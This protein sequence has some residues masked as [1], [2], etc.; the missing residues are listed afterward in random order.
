MFQTG[1]TVLDE[2]RGTPGFLALACVKDVGLDSLVGGDGEPREVVLPRGERFYR[3]L[4][5]RRPIGLAKE[6]IGCKIVDGHRDRE[7]SLERGHI[8]SVTLQDVVGQAR[9]FHVSAGAEQLACRRERLGDFGDHSRRPQNRQLRAERREQVTAVALSPMIGM[10]GDLVDERARRP[11]GADQDADRV[12]AREG[13]HAAAAPDLKVA[14]RPFERGRRHRRLVGEVRR[15]AAIQRID[16]ELD[17]VGATEAVRAHPLRIGSPAA[18]TPRGPAAGYWRRTAR[19][20]R[21]ERQDGR[22]TR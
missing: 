15:P 1:S 16:Q 20:Q 14:D 22:K 8:G 10:D 21:P 4:P 12:G 7:K 3:S 19:R 11:L 6:T 18:R 5:A 9:F 17:V 2:S 13:D